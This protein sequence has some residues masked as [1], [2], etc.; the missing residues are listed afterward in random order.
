M[1]YPES[2]HNRAQRKGIQIPMNN[3]PEIKR[4]KSGHTLP[5]SR[6]K[7]GRNTPNLPE[8]DTRHHCS[9]FTCLHPNQVHVLLKYIYMCMLDNLTSSEK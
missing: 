5:G 2:R 9:N 4:S 8:Q 3:I 6:P 7:N 1:N